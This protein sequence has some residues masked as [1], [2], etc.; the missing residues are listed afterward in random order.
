YQRLVWM[1]EWK[2][3]FAR[4]VIRTVAKHLNNNIRYTKN[5]GTL[6]ENLRSL[7]GVFVVR[8]AGFRTRSSFHYNFQSRLGQIGDDR[9][10]ECYATLPW[11]GFVGKPKNHV[12]SSDLA[13]LHIKVRR[14]FALR[15]KFDE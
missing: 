7:C 6:R 11:I 1:K 15:H 9:R 8:I 13:E 10:H 14:Q 3:I 4:S 5:L 12:T 2:I